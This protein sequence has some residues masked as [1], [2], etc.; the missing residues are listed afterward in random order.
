MARHG[1]AGLAGQRE[2]CP[3][4]RRPARRGEAGHG[5]A[6]MASHVHERNHMQTINELVEQECNRYASLADEQVALNVVNAIPESDLRLLLHPFVT[7]AVCAFRRARTRRHERDVLGDGSRVDAYLRQT[8][9]IGEPEVQPEPRPAP[10]IRGPR[11]NGPH[12][13]FVREGREV[14]VVADGVGGPERLVIPAPKMT[15]MDLR[16]YHIRF[17]ALCRETVKLGDGREMR[18]G[19]LTVADLDARDA[20]LLRQRDGIDS[21]LATDAE[22]KAVLIRTGKR[23]MDDVLAEGAQTVYKKR[24]S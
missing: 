2:A 20:M 4:R 24:V 18:W 9:Q 13:T 7:S 6:G 5:E 8:G 22:A 21:T 12:I 14:K 23:C 17:E 1:E 16:K 19:Q 15:K 11:V 10:I 3:A